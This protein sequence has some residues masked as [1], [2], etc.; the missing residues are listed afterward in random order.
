M[1]TDTD[2]N[3]RQALT[4]SSSDLDLWPPKWKNFILDW[5]WTFENIFQKFLQRVHEIL[6]Q[7]NGDGNVTLPKKVKKENEGNWG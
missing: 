2:E 5:V 3:Y 6:V 4:V 7:E 1:C